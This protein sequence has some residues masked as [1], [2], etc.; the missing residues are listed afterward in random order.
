MQASEGKRIK[1]SES[2]QPGE[3]APDVTVRDLWHQPVAEESR[4]VS[5]R[6]SYTCGHSNNWSQGVDIP[7][8]PSSCRWTVAL[9]DPVSNGEVRASGRGHSGSGQE[10]SQVRNGLFPKVYT[11]MPPTLLLLAFAVWPWLRIP[12]RST[13]SIKSTSERREEKDLVNIE[14][15][16]CTWGTHLFFVSTVSFAPT[17]LKLLPDPLPMWLTDYNSLSSEV[18]QMINAWFKLRQP[19]I[20]PL[21]FTVDTRKTTSSSLEVAKL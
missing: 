4:S 17:S 2:T 1:M 7:L 10:W 12:P 18:A 14:W 20:F 6:N 21:G 3:L 19:K 11:E 9:W 5:D 8:T 16:L 13:Y 15:S